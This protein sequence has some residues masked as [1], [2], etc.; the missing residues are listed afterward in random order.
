MEKY[1]GQAI[2]DSG[3]DRSDIFLTTKLWPRDYGREKCR[4]A[5]YQSMD[6]LDTDYLDLYMLHFPTCPTSVENPH[7]VVEETWRELELMLDE[8]KIRAIGVS[9]F[10]QNDLERLIAAE[11]TSG[12]VP[13]VNQCEF[14]PYQN[15]ADLLDFCKEYDIQFEGFCPLGKGKLLSEKPIVELAKQFGKSPAQILIR[16]AIQK[17]VLTIP[18]ST[19]KERV[20]ENYQSLDFQLPNTAME[21][22]NGLHNNFR[23]IE[24]DNV[25]Q[26][27]DNDHLVDGYKLKKFTCILPKADSI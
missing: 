8:E 15:P 16:W 4:L 24:L 5:A 21:I 14:H 26:R 12:I 18:K 6:R 10:Q 27:L 9:N 23:I 20:L 2:K 11:E 7:A 19:K 13:H 17:D 25:R 22:L 3:V 1:L